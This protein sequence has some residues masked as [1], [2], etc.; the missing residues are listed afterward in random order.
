[1]AY[2]V[3]EAPPFINIDKIDGTSGIVSPFQTFNWTGGEPF[4]LSTL[5]NPI[6]KSTRLFASGN[7]IAWYVEG[8]E[9]EPVVQYD[10]NFTLMEMVTLNP[11]WIFF[12]IRD[13][14]EGKLFLR[15]QHAFN[16]SS[17]AIDQ[18][19]IYS[20]ANQLYQPNLKSQGVELNPMG[21][22]LHVCGPNTYVVLEILDPVKLHKPSRITN[23]TLTISVYK[24][25][26]LTLH[27]K[28]SISFL[29]DVITIKCD[30]I[31]NHLMILQ[32]MKSMERILTLNALL[33]LEIS[34]ELVLVKKSL[35]SQPKDARP[36][37]F[38]RA[39][40]DVSPFG[41]VITLLHAPKYRELIGAVNYI[42]CDQVSKRGLTY[43]GFLCV[44][45]HVIQQKQSSNLS[46]AID[47]N[48][49]C[50]YFPKDLLGTTGGQDALTTYPNTTEV[51]AKSPCPEPYFFDEQKGK[52]MFCTG[53]AE[54]EQC[55]SMQAA[56]TSMEQRYTTGSPL[57]FSIIG[58]CAAV[59]GG[60]FGVVHTRR[61]SNRSRAKR[62][63]SSSSILA[64]SNIPPLQR[65]A[66]KTE[67]FI[68]ASRRGS[69][70]TILTDENE[71]SGSL[72]SVTSAESQLFRSRSNTFGTQQSLPYSARDAPIIV[73][74][75]NSV[76][77]RSSLLFP[78]F[79][80]ERIPSFPSS[81]SMGPVIDYTQLDGLSSNH[82][83][84]Q[85]MQYN[86][87][88]SQYS[89]L[90]T[91]L[92]VH[93]PILSA[94]PVPQSRVP[95]LL[96]RYYVTSPTLPTPESN[97]LAPFPYANRRMSRLYSVASNVSVT[98]LLVP[99]IGDNLSDLL[100]SFPSN[101]HS[102]ISLPSHIAKTSSCITIPVSPTQLH[103][104]V[105]KRHY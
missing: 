22:A 93:S 78:S 85:I 10:E 21:Q 47:Q 82:R 45:C 27:T 100:G 39:S 14:A 33:N 62:P 12:V 25:E 35:H 29:G 58:G 8:S 105:L 36:I 73:R 54:N 2:K 9:I 30:P 99:P 72:R 20:G 88:F 52:C 51:D 31:R 50:L 49:L 13:D 48:N 95:P 76:P 89:A 68:E 40:M 15:K 46:Q 32:S 26:D 28:K 56:G 57:L 7:E 38:E 11:Y 94:L 81:N 42:S 86:P 61:L 71:P 34:E 19:I 66:S 97:L 67:S 80:N 64:P 5:I 37:D 69:V 91:P 104:P 43:S 87:R 59:V 102:E 84:P 53:E 17:Q 1:V 79:E 70:A 6:T 4:R 75:L 23:T 92:L 96:N 41:D 3:D 103:P 98:T 77:P 90:N 60:I 44:P 101:S 18:E 55:K 63:A 74:S 83:H 16:Y 24:S 65:P